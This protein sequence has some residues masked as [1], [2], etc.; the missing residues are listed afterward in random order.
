VE[1]RTHVETSR[2]GRKSTKGVDIFMHDS[3]ENLGAPTLE[4]R[5]LYKKMTSSSTQR[6]NT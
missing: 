3:R 4:C 1:A 6:K 2:D 5:P